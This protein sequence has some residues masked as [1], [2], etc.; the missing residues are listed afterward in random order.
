MCAFTLGDI[1]SLTK[2][3]PSSPDESN[4]RLPRTAFGY[5]SPMARDTSEILK[6]AMA[7]PPEA[8][9]ALAES[10]LDSIDPHTDAEAE[11]AWRGEI[12]RRVAE[13]DSGA[14]STIPW[15]EARR[16]LLS[17]LSK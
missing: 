11:E 1:Q 14:V 6:E 4:V 16:R 10:L 2:H 12:Q 3:R 9:A 7:L 8:R 17:T 15:S 5:N 13:L